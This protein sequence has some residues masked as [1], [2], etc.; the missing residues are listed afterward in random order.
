MELRDIE[1]FLV[2]AEE[3]HFGRTAQ[4][5]H[6]T[7]AR[8][9]QAIKQQERRVGGQLFERTS[10]SVRLTPLGEQLRDDLRPL[11]QGLLE[12]V[13]RAQ[14]AA[15]GVS[16]TLTLGT[17]GPQ[18]WMLDEVLASFRDLHPGVEL[19]HRDLNPVI[20][21]AQLYAGEVDVAHVWLPVREPGL[22]VGPVTHSSAQ[23]L[24]VAATHPYAERDSICRED[25]GDLVF[26]A[27]QSRIPSYMEEVFQPF[28]TPSG[29]AI[30]RGPVVTS[31]EDQLKAA[32]AGQA[33]IACVAEAARF[34]SWPNLVF[35]PIRD[36]PP[37]EWAFVWRTAE[38]SSLL[39]ALVQTV[40]DH[41]AT[42]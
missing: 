22:T 33:V 26:V 7:Q 38:E 4:R 6:V 12:S 18:M 29:R 19:V 17:M 20:P 10:R 27:H 34:Y 9:S 41:R 5:L 11:Y 13:A 25:F 31:W 40:L 36:A 24:V 3:L 16:G 35:L 14:Q 21:L 42:R 30:P 23:V 2:L 37:V 15:R 28:R 1:I 8:V 39:R 32:S